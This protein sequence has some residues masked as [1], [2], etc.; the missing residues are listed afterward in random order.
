MTKK[1]STEE[2]KQLLA[3]R[4]K[5]DVAEQAA[6]KAAYEKSK[7]AL[8]QSIGIV[9]IDL[10]SQLAEAKTL[11]FQRM[12]TFKEEMLEYGDIKGGEKNKGN[13]EIKNE[14]FKI[15]YSSAVKKEFDERAD[16]AEE[17]LKLFL[18]GFVKKRDKKLYGL[19]MGMLERNSVTGDLDINNINR[20]YKHENDFD[21][22][23]WKDALRLFKEAYNPTTTSNYIRIYRRNENNGWDLVNLNFSSI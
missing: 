19:I 14:H 18:N 8:I 20:L 21:D 16:L 23:D 11:F 3:E 15:Q 22:A 12:H 9:G 4:Q 2:L 5:E 10:F 13:F 17:K 6:K 7:N 1:L